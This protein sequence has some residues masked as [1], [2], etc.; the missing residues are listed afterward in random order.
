[1]P[2]KP[3]SS[4]R[5]K[6]SK[7]PKMSRPLSSPKQI[8]KYLSGSL[9]TFNASHIP[10]APMKLLTFNASPISSTKK[11]YNRA[12]KKLQGLFRGHMA[13]KMTKKIKN[14]AK[15]MQAFIRGR[16]ARNRTGRMRNERR[17]KQQQAQQKRAKTLSR[18]MARLDLT[19]MPSQGP[20]TTRSSR[21]P[22]LDSK[23]YTE[24]I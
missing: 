22:P 10:T 4:K 17:E 19:T 15:K 12:A 24:L 20:R 1:M 16:S 13:R 3:A 8:T 11:R 14:A 2:S 9:H 5:S 6:K 23:K 7:T 18:E 21:P